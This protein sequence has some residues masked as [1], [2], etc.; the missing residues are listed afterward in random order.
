MSAIEYV[1][2][3]IWNWEHESRLNEVLAVKWSLLKEDYYEKAK[4]AIDAYNEYRDNEK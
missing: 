2:K 3:A 4:V 1:A